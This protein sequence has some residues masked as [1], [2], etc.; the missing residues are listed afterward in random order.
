MKFSETW[1]G[2]FH[3]PKKQGFSDD[4]RL[5]AY[6]P[7]SLSF[8]DKQR[9]GI[10]EAFDGCSSMEDHI[11]RAASQPFP[12]ASETP[13]PE[14]TRTAAKFVAENDPHLVAAFWDS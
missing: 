11:R 2:P 8:A 6:E 14:E 7:A 5:E 1:K 12:L 13:I 4:V 9:K 10:H 3:R